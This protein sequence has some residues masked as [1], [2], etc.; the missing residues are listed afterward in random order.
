MKPSETSAKIDYRF[1]AL[2]LSGVLANKPYAPHGER[3]DEAADRRRQRSVH[4]HLGSQATRALAHAEGAPA[5]EAVPSEPEDEGSQGGIRDV[6]RG[7]GSVRIAALRVKAIDGPLLSRPRNCRAGERTDAARKVHNA[8]PGEVVVAHIVQEAVTPSHR[9][10][11]RIDDTGHPRRKD[12]VA[13]ELESL[14]NAA[15][16]D[17]SCGDAESPLEEPTMAHLLSRIFRKI[18]QENSD[19]CILP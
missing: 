3:H 12:D 19:T 9:P 7:V 13:S 16:D 6:V 8:G 17:G 1:R 2:S 11:C 18:H 5:V 4:R 15:G 10:D 14:G